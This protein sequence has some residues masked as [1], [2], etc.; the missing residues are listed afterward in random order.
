[1]EIF[2]IARVL[3]FQGRRLSSRLYYEK[4][5]EEEPEAGLPTLVNILRKQGQCY[6]FEVVGSRHRQFR[7]EQFL[8][9][10][11]LEQHFP[12]CNRHQT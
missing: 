11:Q 8:I 5:K 4:E 9:S 2:A 10:R 6:V 12:W 1:V 7:C 3:M